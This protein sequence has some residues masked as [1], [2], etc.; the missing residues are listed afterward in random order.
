MPIEPVLDLTSRP[1]ITK[2]SDGGAGVKEK[3]QAFIGIIFC[4][5]VKGAVTI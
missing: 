4:S 2:F 3:P 1:Q 5:Y